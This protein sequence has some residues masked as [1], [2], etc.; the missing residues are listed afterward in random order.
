MVLYPGKERPNVGLLG[1]VTGAVVE[2]NTQNVT[3]DQVLRIK[4]FP[5]SP[6]NDFESCS[7]FSSLLAQPTTFRPALIKS[8]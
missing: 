5:T 1:Q 3:I 8:K 4:T 7:N 6:D 2:L